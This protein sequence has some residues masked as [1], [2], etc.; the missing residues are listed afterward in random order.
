MTSK[1]LRRDYF[2]GVRKILCYGGGM[3]GKIVGGVRF[4]GGIIALSVIWHIKN[5]SRR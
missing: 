4:Y 5:L 3:F 1:K 2:D